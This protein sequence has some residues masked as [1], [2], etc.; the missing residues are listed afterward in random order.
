MSASN[1]VKLNFTIT[2]D[3]IAV[4][5]NRFSSFGLP[6]DTISIAFNDSADDQFIGQYTEG[7]LI[8]NNRAQWRYISPKKP[9]HYELVILNNNLSEKFILNVFV[10]V[11]ASGQKGE[12]LN[13][14][15]IGEYPVKAY[16][17]L[18]QYNQPEGFVEVNHDNMNVYVSPHLQLKQFLCKQQPDQW[19]KYILLN[20]K[21]L[22]KLE[23]L[24]DKLNN[25]GNEIKT[26]FLMSGYRTP[27]YNTSIGNGRY[28]RHIY[29]DATD[30]YVDVDNNGEIDDLNKDG[31]ANMKDAEVIYNI[32][33]GM[34]NDPKYKYL[35]GGLGKYKKTS[36]HTWNVHI[37]T[38]GYKARW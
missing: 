37:D 9:G 3:N 26:I 35:I 14:Y 5:L 27:W 12:Y 16:R 6:G 18:P 23:F 10:M 8:K 38:R 32:I 15:R 1:S 31:K 29:G 28:S 21:I 17:N 19:P 36:N 33:K 13:G 4:N 7:T 22:L 30:V 2:I 24:L 11:P 20:P 25:T 34:D